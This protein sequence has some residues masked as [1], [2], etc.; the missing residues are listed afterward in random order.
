MTE[1]DKVAV[2]GHDGW[3]LGIVLVLAV[4]LL[5]AGTLAVRSWAQQIRLRP[6]APP[7]PSSLR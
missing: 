7:I 4:A 1:D 5:V 3:R 2:N 6:P